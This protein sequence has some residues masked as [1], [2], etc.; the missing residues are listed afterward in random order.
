ML[1]AYVCMHACVGYLDALLQEAADVEHAGAEHEVGGRAVRHAVCF[2]LGRRC[3]VLMIRIGCLL[4][5]HVTA[6]K[7]HN[8]QRGLTR[9]C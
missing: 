2:V 4:N 1:D 6:M 3:V 8:I 9:P 5:G 7:A